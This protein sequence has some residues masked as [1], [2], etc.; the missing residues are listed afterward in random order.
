MVYEPLSTLKKSKLYDD[1]HIATIVVE[2]DKSDIENLH[3]NPNKEIK[4]NA[5]ITY[6]SPYNVKIFENGS[7]KISG[8]SSKYYKKLSYKLSGLKLDNDKE[9]FGRTGV[10]L[11]GE[12]GDPS[13]MREKTFFDMLNA[14]GV[15]TS[16]GKF[17]R[18]FINR[19]PAGLY[20]LTDDFNNKH[21]LKS[22]FH[23]GK[24][25]ENDNAIFKVNAGGSLSYI[26]TNK[27]DLKPYSY[28]GDIEDANSYEKTMEILVPFM[29]DVNNYPKTKSLNL[30]INSFLRA[31]ALEYLA[32]GSDNY[33]MVQ[34]N[35]FFF[36]NME[37]NT[38]HFIDND[39][40]QTFGHGHPD[41]CLKK[42]L[43]NYVELKGDDGKRPLLDNLR[44]VD[45]NEKYLKSA[46]E[47]LLKTCFNINAVGP[48][49]DS[50][51]ELLKDDALWDFT[52][53]GLSTYSGDHKLK[54]KT[55]N[56]DDFKREISSTSS[57]SYPYPI[58]KWIIERSTNVAKIYNYSVP[59][60][61]SS[62]DGYF[63]PE[64]EGQSKDKDKNENTTTT[65]PRTTPKPSTTTTN[66][67]STTN[68]NITTSTNN[69]CGPD[70]GVCPKGKCCSRYG[71]C[72]NTVAYCG[73]G[74][75]SEFGE[76][77][78][79][80]N[81][82]SVT[83]TKTTSSTETTSTNTSTINTLPTSLEKCG[84]G[85]AV[86]G[87]NLCCS[88]YGYCGN[89]VAYCGKGCQSEF[90]RCDNSDNNT[91]STTTKTTSSSKTTS[92]NTSTINTLPTSS[93]KCGLGV[94]VCGS[95]LCCSKY[96]YCGDS[97][98]YCGKG[99]QSEFGRCDT[100]NNNTST[101]TTTTTKKTST[102]KKSSTSK[103]SS[104]TKKTSTT[105][106]KTTNVSTNNKCGSEYGICPNGG[107]CSKYGYCGTEAAYCG[108]GCKKDYGE[109]W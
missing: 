82:V 8:Q 15:P 88:R 34:G 46:V 30:D 53:P 58:K 4:V 65:I 102:T 27:T 79:D 54:V 36:K 25:F 74:C 21:F 39:F 89:T 60:T 101:T 59:E 73:K 22:V 41:K 23:N 99:C 69:Q 49:L 76:C 62:S 32:Y 26:S 13:F 84:P 6:V 75:Q 72:G 40:D 35:F 78:N 67:S 97:S 71:Y 7:I 37:T 68:K 92:T 83:T 10:K 87:N 12:Y 52:L 104:T 109:C 1:T 43:D 106:M 51:A 95:N 64:Y 9:L 17:V 91:S 57:T 16:Q 61:P 3:Q 105:T 2:S 50:F 100:S 94:A 108:T 11:R 29:K 38:W 98:A 86:C 19:V 20:L 56:E 48:R 63:E 103:K 42:T 77:T 107:C 47:K 66:T 81:N 90:G 24:K 70:Y 28:K 33:W 96:G 31:M 5:K 18:L 44:T 55:H 80:D 45:A 93:G 14:L 85:V